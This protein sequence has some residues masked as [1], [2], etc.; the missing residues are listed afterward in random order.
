MLLEVDEDIIDNDSY[1]YARIKIVVI[2]KVPTAIFLKV[3]ERRWKLQVKVEIPSPSREK[4]ELRITVQGSA[5]GVANWPKSGCKL[6]A[7][8]RWLRQPLPQRR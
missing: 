7:N 5:L 4:G 2:K 3:G 6:L 1:L 8:G